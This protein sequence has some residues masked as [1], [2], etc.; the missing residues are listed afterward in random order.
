M[1]EGGAPVEDP[2]SADPAAAAPAFEMPADLAAFIKAEI[3]KGVAAGMAALRPAAA[4][5][6]ARAE[7]PSHAEAM[8]QVK[9]NGGRAILSTE[10]YVCPLP[11]DVAVQR[12]AN[13][14]AKS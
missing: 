12:D 8:K 10:G 6:S 9:K 14:F 13:G 5:P 11:A 7:L 3:A 4:A 1:P 2:D